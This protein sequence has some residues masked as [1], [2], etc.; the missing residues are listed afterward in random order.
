VLG[1]LA[2]T[3]AERGDVTRAR[4]LLLEAIPLVREHGAHG[5]LIAVASYAEELGLTEKL[6]AAVEDAPKPTQHRW[7]EAI[8]I[9]LS[10]DLRGAADF[11]ADM[12]SPTLE[13]KLRLR[14]GERLLRG[15]RPDEGEIELRRALGFYVGVDATAYVERIERAL[16]EAQSESA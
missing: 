6:R 10:G 16:A 8:L 4:R 7:P 3:Y 11:L 9:A 12:G 1:L 15:G 14:A 2:E 5:S 13:A